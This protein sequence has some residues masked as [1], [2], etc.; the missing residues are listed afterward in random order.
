VKDQISHSHI[1]CY[2]NVLINILDAKFHF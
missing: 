2:W 1:K